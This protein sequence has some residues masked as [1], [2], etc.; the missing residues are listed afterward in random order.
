MTRERVVGA[1]RIRSRRRRD[2]DVRIDPA[3]LRIPAVTDQTVTGRPDERLTE[4]NN[5]RRGLDRPPRARTV[6]RVEAYISRI[7]TELSQP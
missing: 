5:R 7:E 4:H 2:L 1:E 3:L 6:A